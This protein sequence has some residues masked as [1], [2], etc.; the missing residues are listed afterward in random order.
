M[1][2]VTTAAQDHMQNYL[3]LHATPLSWF[4]LRVQGGGC[5]GFRYEFSIDHQR[6]NED[7]VVGR[8]VIDAV[9]LPFVQGCTIDYQDTLVQAG[10]VIQNPMASTHC[11]CGNSFS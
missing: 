6:D 3:T 10:F 8:L 4:R 5:A 7:Y 9:S 11:G 2:I 1:V